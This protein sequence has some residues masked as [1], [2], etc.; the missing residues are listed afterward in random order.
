MRSEHR[1]RASRYSMMSGT[2]TDADQFPV[3]ATL[4]HSYGAFGELTWYVEE[5][6]RVVAGARLD[7]SDAKDYRRTLGMMGMANPTFGET[8]ADTL[9][10]GFARY[11]HD[12]DS[13]TT[14]YAGLG[15]VQRFPDYWELF[16]P[17]QG[18]A[19]AQRLR[20]REAGEDHPAR[21]RRA[22]QRGR[23]GGLGVRLVGQVRDYILFTYGDDGRHLAGREHR[24]A[25]HGRRAG[26]GLP[27]GRQL[28]D[29]R[30][31]GLRLGQEQLR[32]PRAAAD[33][34]AGSAPGPDLRA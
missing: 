30:H 16:S 31:P 18:P 22:V 4:M 6:D 19:G 5:G 24:R 13:A 23:P 1:K 33:A 20:W 14:V 32:R 7:R 15:H 21:L 3:P 34:A 8:R 28:E 10:S 27:P 17:N 11:E 2:F 29:R 25:H 26:R 12:L 9:P